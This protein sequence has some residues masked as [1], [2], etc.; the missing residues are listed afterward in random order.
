MISSKVLTIILL[1]FVAI[2]VIALSIY[3]WPKI[4]AKLSGVAKKP[5]KQKDGKQFVL[6]KTEEPRPTVEPNIGEEL[7]PMPDDTYK[8]EEL[9]SIKEFLKMP[10]KKERSMGDDEIPQAPRRPLARRMEIDRQNM[11]LEQE[12]KEYGYDNKP[13]PS[14]DDINDDNLWN[15]DLSKRLYLDDRKDDAPVNPYMA[16]SKKEKSLKEELD[17]LSPEMKKILLADILKKK[18]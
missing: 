17:T 4:K 3:L 18:G 16:R 2:F 12:R 5:K 13:L 15:D 11:K 10:P 6:E 14:L 7:M 1:I 9:A 8:E